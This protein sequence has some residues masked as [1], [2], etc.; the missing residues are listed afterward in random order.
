[1]HWPFSFGTPDADFAGD[2]AQLT[3]FADD[4]ALL[5]NTLEQ[6]QLL[7]PQV[8]TSAKQT[9]LHMNNSKMEYIKFNQ[10]EGALKALNSE[11][12]KNV[13]DF[14]YLGSRIDCCSKDVN[15]R[16]GK[17]WFAIHK[18]DIIWKLELSDCLKIGFFR[19]T[20]ETVLLYGL[21]AWTLTQFL[22]KKVGRGK[23]K[24]AESGEECDLA[25]AYYK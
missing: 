3:D 15:V 20:V 10:G 9:G 21:P 2:T 16:I 25:E 7:L 8:E 19:A 17:A 14:L 12:L 24:N 11:S 4:I 22:A 6:A 13:D 23:Y 1:M 18:L 5:S